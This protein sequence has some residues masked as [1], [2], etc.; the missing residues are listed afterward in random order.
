MP[1][2]FRCHRCE[3]SCAFCYHLRARGCGCTG[4]PA[5]PTPSLWA[6]R[7][8]NGPGGTRRGARKPGQRKAT[9]LRI[10]YWPFG[11]SRES[12]RLGAGAP[13]QGDRRGRRHH[14]R[15][16]VGAPLLGALPIANWLKS[17]AF[18]DGSDGLSPYSPLL[19]SCYFPVFNRSAV[20]GAVFRCPGLPDLLESPALRGDSDGLSQYSLL[21]FSLLIGLH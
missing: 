13:K 19:L 16:D 14:H 21:L 17:P 3:Y 15:H 7:S 20:A 5:F 18:R 8:C 12:N 10:A 1:G 9:S 2:D 6:L 11:R 4:H